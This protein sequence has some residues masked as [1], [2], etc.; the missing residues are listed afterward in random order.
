[1]KKEKILLSDFKMPNKKEIELILKF[2][3]PL[4]KKDINIDNI[5]TIYNYPNNSTF[6]YLYYIH[7]DFHKLLYEKDLIIDIVSNGNQINLPPNFYFNLLI[8]VQKYSTINYKFELN[9]ITEL[10]EHLKKYMNGVNSIKQGIISK[11]IIDLIH[12][13]KD[14]DNYDEN[15]EYEILNNI[16]NEMINIIYNVDIF[17]QISYS[18]N[19]IL[20]IKI[21]ELYAEI[22]ILL[23]KEKKLE[24]FSYVYNIIRQL[25]LKQI[26]ITNVSLNRILSFYL[27][28][29]VYFKK[30]RRKANFT[31]FNRWL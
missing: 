17:N 20:D 27:E 9:Y 13:Y 2:I 26:N 10:Y 14:T 21:D 3:I 6:K 5:K 29:K 22:I 1:M 12:N 16:E 8:N 24:N 11:F 4:Y 19:N 18:G 15:K 28:I 25:E 30:R 23:I 7:N 31:F